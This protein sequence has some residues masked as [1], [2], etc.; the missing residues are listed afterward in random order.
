[1]SGVL[2]SDDKLAYSVIGD[3]VNTASRLESVDKEGVMT[4]ANEECR[5]LIGSLTY[6]YIKD[7]FSAKYLGT[8]NL[9]GKAVTT[10]V[11]KVLDP[12]RKEEQPPSQGP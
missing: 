9:K 7:K 1:M 2:G 6:D 12:L 3:T 10:D 5:I 11:Y 4:S 8:V